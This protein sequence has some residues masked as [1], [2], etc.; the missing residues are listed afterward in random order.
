M[1]HVAPVRIGRLEVEVICEGF[2]PL[3]LADECPGRPV[4][5][6]AERAV[7]PWAFH[8][9]RSWPWHVHAFV[10][11]GPAGTTLVDSGVG[12]FGPWRPWA[13]ADPTAWNG[14]DRNDV[15]DVVLTH[16]H[17]DHAGGVVVDG[18]A[19]F[20]NAMVHVHPGDWQAF[21][22]A[23]ETEDYVV[24]T[25]LERVLGGGRLDLDGTDHEVSAGVFVRHTPGHT[26]G[27][28][29]VLVRDG[30]A[31]LLITGDLLH[32]PV[33]A[34]HPEWPSSHDDDPRIG[35]IAR[36]LTLW[37]AANAGWLVAVNH[38]ASPFG[39]VTPEGWAG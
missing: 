19:R 10:I 27:H 9:V 17:A 34:A 6:E 11:R 2:A 1:G 38:F 8:G 7:H 21:A 18:E 16:L 13:H 12:G 20:P 24:R 3:P 36:R 33:Q 15:R 14:I 22:A 39:S 35:A 25:S 37:R 23:D 26:P 4:D 5:W 29:S 32:L 31:T 28:R 30:G